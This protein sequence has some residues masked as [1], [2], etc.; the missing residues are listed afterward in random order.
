MSPP[1]VSLDFVCTIPVCR[2]DMI[3][4]FQLDHEAQ[5][6]YNSQKDLFIRRSITDTHYDFSESDVIS[7]FRE[8]VLMVSDE[9]TQS[10]PWYTTS[11]SYWISAAFFCTWLFGIALV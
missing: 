8:N 1:E 6:N 9:L 10:D 11:K 5:D 2:L 4:E 3:K 7:G